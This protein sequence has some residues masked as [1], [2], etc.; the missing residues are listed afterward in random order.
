M[1]DDGWCLSM[2]GDGCW[3]RRTSIKILNHYQRAPAWEDNNQQKEDQLWGREPFCYTNSE[4]FF[5]ECVESRTDSSIFILYII[6]HPSPLM[7]ILHLSVFC[8]LQYWKD[9]LL[10]SLS[11]VD[12][13]SAVSQRKA[14]VATCWNDPNLVPHT[15]ASQSLKSGKIRE[16]I[17]PPFHAIMQRLSKIR[18]SIPCLNDLNH[19]S[20]SNLL[21][22]TTQQRVFVFFLRQILL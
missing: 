21:R 16:L 9:G 10:G 12:W 6:L 2:V 4:V 20:D 8:V 13:N 17:L 18:D 3:Y 19:P 7:T 5:Q 11:R 22:T 1:V 15:K 14:E